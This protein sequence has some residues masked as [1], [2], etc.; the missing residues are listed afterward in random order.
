MMRRCSSAWVEDVE[1]L[2]K[3]VDREGKECE[4]FTLILAT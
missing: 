1:A 4:C 3:Q 2:V